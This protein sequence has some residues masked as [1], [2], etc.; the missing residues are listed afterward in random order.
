MVYWQNCR[1]LVATFLFR[2]L[3]LSAFF[4]CCLVDNSA[5]RFILGIFSKVKVNYHCIV[6][7][8]LHC[9]LVSLNLH[10]KNYIISQSKIAPFEG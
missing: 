3:I 10:Q 1:S 9:G 4:D 5:F 6:L 7:L 8:I 2:A